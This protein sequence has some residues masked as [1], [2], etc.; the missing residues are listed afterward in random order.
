MKFKKYFS[1]FAIKKNKYQ[2]IIIITYIKY[3]FYI[4]N[5]I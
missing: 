2:F 4:N 5:R 3:I 1:D